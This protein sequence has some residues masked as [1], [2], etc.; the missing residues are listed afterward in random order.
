MQKKPQQQIYG[1]INISGWINKTKNQFVFTYFGVLLARWTSYIDVWMDIDIIIVKLLLNMK[2]NAKTKFNA[3]HKTHTKCYS[4]INFVLWISNAN[5][6][7]SFYCCIQSWIRHWAGA[8]PILL[9][10][11]SRRHIANDVMFSYSTNQNNMTKAKVKIMTEISGTFSAF[12]LFEDLWV[13][14]L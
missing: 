11:N 6:F 4:R 3:H 1:K 13:A 14:N 2:M 9:L 8:M 7:Q 10:E 12:N 5:F